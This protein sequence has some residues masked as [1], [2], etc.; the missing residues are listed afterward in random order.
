[1]EMPVTLTKWA[2][3]VSIGI[4]PMVICSIVAVLYIY[5]RKVGR[6]L[7]EERAGFQPTEWLILGIVIGFLGALF[8]NIFWNAAWLANWLKL[9]A[10]EALFDAGPVSNVAFRQTFKVVSATC[11]IMGAW[12]MARQRGGRLFTVAGL[13]WLAAAA[14][15][16]VVATWWL[17]H[18]DL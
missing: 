17:A 2:Q 13:L 18:A 4:G 8:D 1:M 3:L 11:H 15:S 6:I 14:L 12:Q 16:A 5:G 7:S 10:R 9:P